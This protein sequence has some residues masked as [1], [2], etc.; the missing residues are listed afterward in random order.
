MG[1]GFALEADTGVDQ[2]AHLLLEA[3]GIPALPSPGPRVQTDLPHEVI[4]TVAQPNVPAL[5]PLSLG[6]EPEEEEPGNRTVGVHGL[7]R[8]S[9]DVGLDHKCQIPVRAGPDRRVARIAVRQ[10]ALHE[11][12]RHERRLG[13]IWI[14]FHLHG[15][16]EQEL[17][18]RAWEFGLGSRQSTAPRL[19]CFSCMHENMQA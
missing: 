9:V 6:H 14:L 10:C 1:F 17:V 15:G 5:L 18:C 11:L 12:P 2:P 16:I 13:R 8:L 3:L 19:S 4:E 7:P